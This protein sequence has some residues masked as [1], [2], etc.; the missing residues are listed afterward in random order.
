MDTKRIWAVAFGCKFATP[1]SL[2]A[3]NYRVRN[4]K[5]KT[6]KTSDLENYKDLSSQMRRRDSQPLRVLWQPPTKGL[7][8]SKYGK[9]ILNLSFLTTFFEKIAKMSD[10]E[11]SKDLSS[12]I[13]RPNSQTPRELFQL[14][15]IMLL[16]FDSVEQTLN[17]FQKKHLNMARHVSHAFKY[18]I[19]KRKRFEVFF[20]FAGKSK[21]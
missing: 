14:P 4:F 21:N 2:T 11:S 16:T 7:G 18:G 8:I 15:T 9:Q 1:E 6:I 19:D 20:H 13:W 17:L 10:L 3:P 5:L 12:H